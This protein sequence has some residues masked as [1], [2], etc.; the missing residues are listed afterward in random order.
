M[1][2]LGADMDA[3][4]QAAADRFGI[5]RTDMRCVDILSRLGPM[6]PKDLA[7]AMGYTTGGITTVIDR[8]EQ[9]GYACRRQDPHDRRKVLV[10]RTGLASKQGGPIFGGLTRKFEEQIA[11]TPDGELTVIRDFLRLSQSILREHVAGVR[12]ATARAADR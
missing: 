6:Q 11:E 8:L 3:L 10:E 4:D 9:S 2:A 5:N 1:R 7:E 12:E